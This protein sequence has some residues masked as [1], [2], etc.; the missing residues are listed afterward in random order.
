MKDLSLRWWQ[1]RS[2]RAVIACK[3]LFRAHW[4]EVFRFDLVALPPLDVVILGI[5]DRDEDDRRGG[6]DAFCKNL[7]PVNGIRRNAFLVYFGG[8]FVDRRRVD[9]V[10]KT[11]PKPPFSWSLF[12]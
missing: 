2:R 12:I 6:R 9:V 7:I 5:V 11:S 3:S 1:R 4:S 8:E 10:V